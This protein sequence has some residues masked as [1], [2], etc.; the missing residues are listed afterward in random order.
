LVDVENAQVLD[1][2]SGVGE[3]HPRRR[4]RQRIQAMCIDV[5]N[6]KTRS[7]VGSP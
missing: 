2:L 7:A 3:R 1:I 6:V 4:F 5:L